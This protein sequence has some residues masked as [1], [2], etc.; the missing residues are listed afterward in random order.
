MAVLS[1]K[2]SA[3]AWA[4]EGVSGRSKSTGVPLPADGVR[5]LTGEYEPDSIPSELWEKFREHFPF[6]RGEKGG[7]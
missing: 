4:K 5:R 1:F 7:L 3:L 2:T 6:R